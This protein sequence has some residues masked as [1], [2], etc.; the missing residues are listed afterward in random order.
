MAAESIIGNWNGMK[1]SLSIFK[2]NISIKQAGI[3]PS[4]LYVLK[5]SATHQRGKLLENYMLNFLKAVCY[6]QRWIF[7]LHKIVGYCDAWLRRKLIHPE[8]W[9]RFKGMRLSTVV[10]T[11]ST[12]EFRREMRL[13]KGISEEL[14]KIRLRI[15]RSNNDRNAS[16]MNYRIWN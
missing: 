13:L 10:L 15:E 6:S 16:E 1:S 3:Y 9:K 11:P 7:S 8:E 5:I 4:M 2:L 14:H 12:V